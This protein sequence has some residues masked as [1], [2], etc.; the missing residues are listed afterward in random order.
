M[1]WPDDQADADLP[2]RWAKDISTQAF[3]W[4]WRGYDEM[5]TKYLAKVD[6]TES[7]E[8]L[9]RNLTEL[10]F[11][12]VQLLWKRETDGFPS[13][14]P[15]HELPEMM[16][17]KNPSSKPPANDLGFVHCENRLWKLPIE[18][19]ILPTSNTLAEYLKDVRKKFVGGIAG[20]FVGEGG[21]VVPAS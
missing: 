7:P 18:A 5:C 9:E 10:H 3:D 2:V 21:K 8:Q 13:M 17:R 16:K 20:P 19:K 6:L 15:G 1:L 12:E 11:Y 4:V 14:Q